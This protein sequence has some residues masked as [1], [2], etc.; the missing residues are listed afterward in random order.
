M[1]PIF[2]GLLVTAVAFTVGWTLMSALYTYDLS[3]ELTLLRRE[4]TNNTVYLR[5][6]IRELESLMNLKPDGQ[7]VE[8]GT[9]V[10]GDAE[11]LEKEESHPP[12]NG[13]QT[14]QASDTQ[15]SPP[16]EDDRP[17]VTSAPTESPASP[18][19]DTEAVTLPVP[20]APETRPPEAESAIPSLYLIAECNGIIG[21]FDASGELI[22]T[23]NVFVMTLPETDREALAV[24]IPASSWQEACEMLG[25]Y[26]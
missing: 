2:K 10:G 8:P 15:P 14:G 6:R 9:P 23:V 11:D 7:P 1:K 13:G 25:R 3:E 24:G 18:S 16:S 12:A 20:Q 5:S 21:L 22:Q 17:P 26:S 19:P 4:T